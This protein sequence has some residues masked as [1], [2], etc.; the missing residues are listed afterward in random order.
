MRPLC[1]CHQAEGPSTWRY[2]DLSSYLHTCQDQM[3]PT[4]R[5]SPVP[6][7]PL[8]L[9]VPYHLL[10]K[11]PLSLASQELTKNVPE[12]ISASLSPPFGAAVSPLAC[13]GELPFLPVRRRWGEAKS[14]PSGAP[15][16]LSRWKTRQEHSSPP[17][18]GGGDQ[19]VWRAKIWDQF[20][21][22]HPPPKVKGGLWNRQEMD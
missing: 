9:P 10:R 11:E 3:S 15:S 20:P 1:P 22:S 7:S 13:L 6:S 12:V 19:N 16:L 21:D 4:F 5:S 14:S 18:I 17:E 8:T 2:W